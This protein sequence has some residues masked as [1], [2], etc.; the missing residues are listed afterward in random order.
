MQQVRGVS[1]AVHGVVS[2]LAA[3][4]LHP[5]SAAEDALAW[6]LKANG[7]DGWVREV[8]FD[9][10]LRPCEDCAGE[11]VL[12]G[13]RCEW[14]KCKRCRGEGVRREGRRWALDF[15]WPMELVACEVD[16]GGWQRGRHHRPEGF[17]ADCEKLNTALCAGWLVLRVTP[18][19]VRSGE[20]VEWIE[21][22]LRQRREE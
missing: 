22:A 4:G 20:A 16:G 21:Q 6:A 8:Q 12:P 18:E 7:I 17:R 19:Q 13:K 3:E 9:R 2:V 11:G 14:I 15:A 1:R 5:M 10:A